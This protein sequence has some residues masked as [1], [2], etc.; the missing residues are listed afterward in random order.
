MKKINQ[1]TLATIL[2]SFSSISL[3][4]AEDW[5]TM[6]GLGIASHSHPSALQKDFDDL[7]K[8]DGVT[9]TELAIDMLG[10]YFPLGDD[11]TIAGFVINSS[12][13]ALTD[14]VTTIQYNYYIYG[15]SA[16]HFLG[17]EPGDGFF[18]RADAGMAR[19]VSIVTLFGNTVSGQSKSSW[20]FL[21]GV[22]YGIPLSA[23]T[24]ILLGANYALRDIEGEM[25]SAMEF[26]ISGLW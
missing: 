11:Q 26:T 18:V 21:G 15:L 19:A 12:A 23:D 20:G 3:A 13:D 17:S 5:Y 1:L 16:M 4:D 24:R 10:I 25:E 9:R 6:W 14:G 22:G 2:L 8:L 7:E